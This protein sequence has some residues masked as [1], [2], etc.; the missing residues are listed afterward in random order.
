[1]PDVQEV[2]VKNTMLQRTIPF[3]NNEYR[4]LRK[5]DEKPAIENHAEDQL[6]DF[7]Y[8][9]LE[10]NDKISAAKNYQSLYY[11]FRNMF[12]IS[13]VLVPVSLVILAITF[14]C[15]YS[16]KQ[17]GYAI[18]I[19]AINILLFLILIPTARF[20]REKMINKILWSYYVERIHQNETKNEQ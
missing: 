8:Y 2:S 19:A 13:V 12:T 3:L 5:H 20:L 14:F 9:Y 10:V 11:W 16:P 18:S 17:Q 15:E 7:A 1:M 6:F 4:R